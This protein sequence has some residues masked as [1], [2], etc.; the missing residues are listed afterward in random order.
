MK[1]PLA[2]RFLHWTM[3]VIIVGLLWAGL[4]MVSMD[5]AIPAKF[6][7]FYPWHK[8]FGML[9]LL[10]V[11]VRLAIRARSKLPAMPPALATWEIRT[12]KTAHRLLYALMILVPLAG[13]A[14][15]S[16]FTQS[17]GVYFF[18]VN[19]PELLPKNDD[20]F[21][22]FQGLHKALAF[23]L[24]G[25]LVLHALGA[26]KHRFVDRDRSKDVLSRMM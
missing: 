12:A 6:E 7:H 23:A 16:S 15:S 25:T 18:G 19:L 10:L 8:S 4:T 5:D 13:Y 9:I 2:M 21:K 17:D 3:A 1:Y 11:F 14:M 20:R 24:L 22:V 26:L